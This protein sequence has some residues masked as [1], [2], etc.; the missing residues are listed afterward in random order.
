M[1]DAT[2]V[3]IIYTGGTIGSMPSDDRDP[4][5]PLVP[6]S[7]DKVVEKLPNVRDGKIALRGR[8]I[9]L[10]T[11]SWAEPIDSSNISFNDW[12]EIAAT[13]KANY[14]AYEG[15][16]VLHGTDTLA[17]TSSAL[18]FM[19]SN[20]SKPVVIT[21][22]QKPIAETRSD[23]VQ[24]FVT[25]IEIAAA[26]SLDAEVIPEVCVFFRDDVTR[27][28][29]TTKLSASDYG[30]FS[31][32]NYL[33]LASAGEHIVVRGDGVR[34][35]AKQTSKCQP[36]TR[37]KHRFARYLS[38]MSTE[39]LRNML[40]TEGLR[41]VVMQ[42]FGTGNAPT[43]PEFLE[44]IGSAVEEGKIIVDITQCRS[45]E[46]ELG[47]YDVSAGLLARGV[48]SGLDMTPEAALTKLGSVLGREDND[49]RAAD[50]MQLNLKGEQSKSIFNLY[51]EGKDGTEGR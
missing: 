37:A 49:Q 18:A 16:V 39:L 51:F 38:R 47:L 46:V 43:T 44:V 33:P 42:T 31:S 27:G 41:G 35:P 28:C 24:N 48:I 29:R 50:I 34:E 9:R 3:L 8:W 26:A 1:A 40:S 15:F 21:G 25:A 22:S 11:H 36:G 30:A 17:Y 45:G 32:P 20:L 4:M 5:S 6:K 10:G 19:L 23:A 12:K 7:I 2:G 13:I 14:E